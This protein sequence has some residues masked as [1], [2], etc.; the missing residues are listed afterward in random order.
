M[1][2]ICIVLVPRVMMVQMVTMV[3]QVPQENRDLLEHM[4]PLDHPEIRAHLYITSTTMYVP[5][6]TAYYLT[7]TQGPPGQTG[8]VGPKGSRGEKVR[9]V[10]VQVPHSDTSLLVG[11][12]RP[13]WNQGTSR[14]CWST[15]IYVHSLK[16]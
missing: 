2:Y 12:A 3:C 10:V 16:V 1:Y 7:S 15:G 4:V 6:Y 9:L 13:N 5:T 11:F 14:T 8:G